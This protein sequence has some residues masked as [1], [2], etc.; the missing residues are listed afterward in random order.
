M[1]EL[2]ESQPLPSSSAVSAN[3]TSPR[4]LPP[5]EVAAVAQACLGLIFSLAHWPTRMLAGVDPQ[6]FVPG[7]LDRG[8]HGKAQA[9]ETTITPARLPGP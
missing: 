7:L 8:F 6:T 2:E 3:S 1:R 4:A 9:H 5:S